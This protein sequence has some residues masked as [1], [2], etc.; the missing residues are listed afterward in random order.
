MPCLNEAETL[1]ACIRKA[2]AW[3]ARSGI[4]AEVVIADNGSTDGSQALAQSLGARVVQ[5]AQRGYGAALFHGS[6]AAKGEWIIMGDSDDSYDFS[7]LDPFVARLGEGYDLVMGNRFLGGIAPGAMPW[8][9]RYVGNPVLSWIGRV[10]FGCPARDFH[11]G[12]RGF[13]KDA[14][15]RMDLRTTGMEYASEMVIKATLF[16]MRIC[17]VPTML[18]KD[19]RS[20]PPHLRPWRDGWR[21]LRFML[22]FSPRWLFIIPSML[23]LLS[24]LA[25]YV[26]LLPG[27]RTVGGT[28]FDI[29]TLLFAQGGVVLGALGLSAGVAVRLFGMR[30]GLLQTHALLERARRSPVLELGSLAG[31]AMVLVGLGTGVMAFSQWAT[32]GFGQ[33][34]PGGVIREVSISTLLFVLGG[35]VLMTSLLF[36]FLSLPTRRGET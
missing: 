33:L 10:L 32:T 18:S 14:F 23:V 3:I 1:G 16:G 34:I 21:H 17:E 24:S 28:V 26:A 12:L 19:G 20:R 22:L 2:N 7:A 30:E 36:G 8:K 15:L 5:V 6:L 13:R 31:L 35:V 29:H 4:E 27:P 9:N 11:C 25:V